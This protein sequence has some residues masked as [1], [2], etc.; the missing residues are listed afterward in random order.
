MSA[1]GGGRR[2]V[3]RRWALLRHFRVVPK[4]TIVG[5]ALVLLVGSLSVP[6]MSLATGWLV[7]RIVEVA[8]GADR[9]VVALP[10][11]A[12]GLMIA[13]QLTSSAFVEPVRLRTM[14]LVDGAVQQR[15][16]RAVGAKP[17]VAH[18]EDQVYRNLA[19]L[20]TTGV[21]T[22]GTA[23]IGQLGVIS[24][25]TGAAMSAVIVVSVAP[26]AA[27]VAFSVL[28]GKRL[29][30]RRLYAPFLAEAAQRYAPQLRAAWYWQQLGSTIDGAKDLRVFGFAETAVKR[31]DDNAG[32]LAEL[33]ATTYRGSAVASWPAWVANGLAVGLPFWFV[34]QRALDGQV[35]PG[36]LAAV[37][38][39]VVGMQ[40]IGGV[41][42]DTYMVEAALSSVEALDELEA[43]S[44]DPLPSRSRSV[45]PGSVPPRITFEG[46]AFSYPGGS[47]PVFENLDLE[48]EPGQSV[49][50][51]GENGVG[52]STLIKLLARFYEPTSG[53]ILADG[54][55]IRELPIE[56]W[57]SRLAVV[58][59][60]FRHFQLSA[61]Q[62]IALAD[63]GH[64]EHDRI[65]DAAIDAAGARGVIEGLP[66]GVDTILSRA[67]R[68]GA[69]LSGGQ[70]QRIALARALYAAGVGSQVLVLDEPTAHLDVSAEVELFD[71]LLTHAAGKTAI[72]VS[73][74]YSTVR[75]AERIV[76]LGRGGIVED[77]SHEQLVARNGVYAGLYSLQ[78]D[79][80]T[81]ASG[82]V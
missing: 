43:L 6:A 61:R 52:K 68:D 33:L 7:G 74:R 64:P 47:H 53:R 37:L 5:L 25:Y 72:V 34:A 71:Q 29:F 22:I 63:W 70:W 58:F 18:L 40:N 66:N 9:A 57:R 41:G 32:V 3:A 44:A 82:P 20:P 15:V 45:A 80:F 76:V 24:Q 42:M 16:R 8:G 55:D 31:Y 79:A 65:L 12:L 73:H 69:D 59:Q 14:L 4:R 77:G 51:V 28:V 54:V 38:G 48:L 11:A 10:L 39:A 23:L 21:Q 1:A 81:S 35:S 30:L 13:Y 67:Y 26:L 17:G 46:V 49:A 36:R 56:G 50:V 75:R 2:W 78:A 62:N 19:A 60:S 27:A